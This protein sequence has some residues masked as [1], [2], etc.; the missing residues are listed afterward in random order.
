[1][2]CLP[3]TQNGA[4]TGPTSPIIPPVMLTKAE[5]AQKVGMQ[6]EMEPD[7]DIVTSRDQSIQRC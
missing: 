4:S 5:A 3:C 6:K 2:T 1:M 7:I